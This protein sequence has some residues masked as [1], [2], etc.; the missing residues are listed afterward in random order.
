MILNVGKIGKGWDCRFWLEVSNGNIT[1][2][3]F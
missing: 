1:D 2:V 3:L